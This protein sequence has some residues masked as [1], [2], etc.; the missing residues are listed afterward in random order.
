MKPGDRKIGD[1]CK[2]FFHKKAI[3]MIVLI[4]AVMGA[5]GTAFMVK[6]S[7]NP[8]FC[9]TCH[10]MQPYYDSYHDSALLANKHAQADLVCHDCHESSIT[11]QAEE[12]FKFI[13][14]DYQLPLEKRQVTKGFCLEC[15][16]DFETAVIAATNFEE[17]N[18]HDSHNGEMECN[19]CHTMHQPSEVYCAQCHEFNW[20]DELDNGWNK[21]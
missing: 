14:G 19:V 8:A 17:S 13:T 5:G 9:T 16:E 21:M 6:A 2:R 11:I 12:G 18:P 15:H 10:I 1:F 3:L 20:M 7:E 4:V